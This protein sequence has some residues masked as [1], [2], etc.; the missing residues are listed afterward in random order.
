[1]KIIKDWFYAIAVCRKYKI[2][3]NP[4]FFDGSAEFN[5]VYY[6]QY[7]KWTGV[8]RIHPFYGGFL[9]SFLH[10]V[11]HCVSLRNA[12]MKAESIAD[13][14][15]NTQDKLKEEYKAWEFSKLALKGRFNN[16]RAR[17]MFS[18][19]LPSIIDK[20]GEEKAMVDFAN[21]DRRLR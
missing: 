11:G 10:E 1:M 19:Y 6:K 14:E 18:T 16:H 15:Y 3:W 20:H 17:A 9:D 7:K 12:Y 13:F 8:V 5:F 21:Y 4:F 2:M